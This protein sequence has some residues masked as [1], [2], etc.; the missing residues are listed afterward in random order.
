M[1]RDWSRRGL[2]SSSKFDAPKPQLVGIA[3]YCGDHPQLHC[4]PDNAS[5]NARVGNRILFIGAGNTT[6]IPPWKSRVLSMQEQHRGSAGCGCIAQYLAEPLVWRV[7]LDTVA[8]TSWYELP[9]M[10]RGRARSSSSCSKMRK[11]TKG[12]P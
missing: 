8:L 6:D 5:L 12:K 9:G 1:A 10:L 4:E 2:R 7:Q 11:Q 3:T